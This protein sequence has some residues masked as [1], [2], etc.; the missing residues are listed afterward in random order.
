MADFYQNGVVT[1]LHRLRCEESSRYENELCDYA[2]RTPVSLVLPALYTEFKHPA[3]YRIVQEL[4]SVRYLNRIVVALGRA[5]ESEYRHARSF[6]EGFPTPVS[7][8]Q[9][10]H[11]RILRLLEKLRINGIDPGPT[12]KGRSCWLAYGYILA[13]QDTE[14]IALHDCDIRNYSRSLLARLCNPLMNPALQFDFCK[15]YYARY[16]DRLHG[17][18][19]RLFLTP[20]VRAMQTLAPQTGFLQFLDSFRYALAGEF[21]MRT[22]LVELNQIPADWG[23]EVGVLAEVYRN[24]ATGRVCQA[25]LTDSYDHKH[26]ILSADNPEAGLRRMTCEI[27]RSL[28]RTVASEGIVFGT[29]QLRTLQ[30][31]YVR[32][33]EDMIR[34]YRADAVVNGLTFDYHSEQSAVQTFAVSLRDAAN[35]FL[36]N[37][38][39]AQQIPSWIQ[40]KAAVPSFLEELRRAADD[41]D[42][43]ADRPLSVAQLV[44]LP[45]EPEDAEFAVSA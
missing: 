29:D 10:D 7:F 22:G 5:N 34:R 13:C 42:T 40:V 2:S 4:A 30:A 19:T 24:C 6:F 15:G 25:D 33:A 44:E 20:L 16:S 32:C 8:L 12:G 17:R 31:T 1:T 21:S 11:P 41:T 35:Q 43:C 23:L 26:Q 18:V 37:P 3:M 39:G 28:L 38:L 36:E 45:V 14:A 27:A 9:V